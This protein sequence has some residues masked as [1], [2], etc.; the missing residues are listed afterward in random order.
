[1]LESF[2]EFLNR[3]V[4]NSNLGPSIILPII[5]SNR[6]I[7]NNFLQ[8]QSSFKGMPCNAICGIEW[9][10]V[11]VGVFKNTLL[12]SYYVRT[13]S[14]CKI[15]APICLAIIWYFSLRPYMYI[16]SQ[17]FLKFWLINYAI[18]ILLSVDNL[19]QI[20]FKCVPLHKYFAVL[21]FN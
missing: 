13:W 4:F 16:F 6:L 1:M 7:F 12:L 20:Y 11:S 8:Q 5:P 3:K 18:Y 21:I 9:E 19:W 10:T 17:R 15:P 2:P 14:S